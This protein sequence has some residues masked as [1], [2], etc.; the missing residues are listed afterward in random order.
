M[1]FNH[2]KRHSLLGAWLVLY[3]LLA[4]VTPALS[5][6]RREWNRHS[7][8][9]SEYGSRNKDHG[10]ET[11]GEFA[12][13][14]FGV[15]NF[16]VALSIVL[17]AFARLVPTRLKLRDALMQFNRRQKKYLIRLHYGLN[18]IAF[19]T[20]LTHFQL[21]TCR[22]TVLPE[23]GLGI[24]AVIALL[25][26]TMKFKLSPAAMRQGIFR[27]HTSPV[28]LIAAVSILLIGHSIVD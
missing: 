25:G 3:F 12:A 11:T 28:L 26:V 24:M 4:A 5:H 27:F 6:D 18:P 10:N 19:G 1:K 13:W 8:K 23:W 2:P 16:P 15:A 20:A 22:S 9:A 21:S 14:I 17:K 7:E